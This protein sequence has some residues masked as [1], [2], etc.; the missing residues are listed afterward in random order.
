MKISVRPA[1]AASAFPLRGRLPT[2]AGSVT[3]TLRDRRASRR[4]SADGSD[5]AARG[6]RAHAAGVAVIGA[7]G[8]GGGRRYRRHADLLP[9]AVRRGHGR[10]PRRHG[11]PPPGRPRLDPGRVGRLVLGVP[12]RHRGRSRLDK[13]GTSA[14]PR[15]CG[16]AA[17]A[18]ARLACQHY[19]KVF[20]APRVGRAA[21]R[22]RQAAAA[23]V[24]LHAGQG[25]GLP[26]HSLCDRPR[27]ARRGQHNARGHPAPGRRHGQV[28]AGSVHG[29]YDESR[30][31]PGRLEELGIDGVVQRLED[32]GVAIFDSA[33]ERIGQQLA[34]TRW[35][36][37]QR[38]SRPGSRRADQRAQARRA[39]ARR[40]E[41]RRPECQPR[42]PI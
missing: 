29:H 39:R 14:G 35:P 40:H 34:A 25:P 41:R 23:V 13:I 15:R 18:N 19:E 2:P 7:R 27:R 21:R 16:A 11:T 42:D 8:S 28:P 4:V 17:I 26:G 37:R 20:A 12:R 10:L 22:R 5:S 33:R 30:Q 6:R 9:A 24:G 38:N 31:V 32:D 1:G 3:G 36:G